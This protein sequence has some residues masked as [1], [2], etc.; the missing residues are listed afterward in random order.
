MFVSRFGLA[1][2]RSVDTVL[3]LSLTER[4]PVCV[5]VN[6]RLCEWGKTGEGAGVGG[7]WDTRAF[8][9]MFGPT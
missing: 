3:S 4:V 6:S 1:V 7:C 8:L 9:R 5:C 2:R